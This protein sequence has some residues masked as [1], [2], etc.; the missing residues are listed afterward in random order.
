MNHRRRCWPTSV[1]LVLAFLVPLL[2]GGKVK[3]FASK[4]DDVRSYKTYEWLPPRVMTRYGLLEG[5][6]LV[7]PVIRQA[8]NRELAR[9][10]YTEVAEGEAPLAP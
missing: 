2:L 1:L 9:K 3:T 6:E 7:A 5:D 10:G 4:E 8:V